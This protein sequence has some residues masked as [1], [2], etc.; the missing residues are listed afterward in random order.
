VELAW[1]VKTQPLQK[2]DPRIV[3][4]VLLEDILVKEAPYAQIVL[5]IHTGTIVSRRAVLHVLPTS[6]LL[7]VPILPLIAPST[8]MVLI[9]KVC[10]HME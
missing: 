8:I 5:S 10:P 2:W 6:N 9:V 7:L 1:T 3:Q 4:V